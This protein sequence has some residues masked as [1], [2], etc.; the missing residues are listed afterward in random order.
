MELIHVI[1]TY[2]NAV[3]DDFTY[4]ITDKQHREEV[5]NKAED[6][7]I[8][9]LVRLKLIPPNMERSEILKNSFYKKDNYKV[10]IKMVSPINPEDIPVSDNLVSPNVVK[11]INVIFIDHDNIEFIESY[12]DYDR[13]VI[14]DVY[15]K[16]EQR[17]V[18][19]A[20]SLNWNSNDDEEWLST[21]NIFDRC[22]FGSKNECVSLVYSDV[23]DD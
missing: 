1:K 12:V 5:I 10:F 15:V 4:I 22:F 20:K 7:Y 23:M 8:E 9:I 21:L 16:A 17:Y 11:V 14:S 13:D 2:D 3:V 6:K 19:M 18:N